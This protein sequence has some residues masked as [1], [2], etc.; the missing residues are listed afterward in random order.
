MAGAL[1]RSHHAVRFRSR[2]RLLLPQ[3]FRR[4][5]RVVQLLQGV[6]RRPARTVAHGLPDRPDA[7]RRGHNERCRRAGAHAIVFSVAAAL[8]DRASQ[9]LRDA[10]ARRRDFPQGPRAARRRRRPRQQSDRR[11]GLKRRHP[12]RRQPVRQACAQYFATARRSELLDLYEPQRRTVAVEFVQEQSIANK[13]RLEARDP[14]VRQR[15]LDELR[16]IAAD[17]ARARQFLLRTSMIASQ[18]RAEALALAKG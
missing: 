15:N 18:R 12:G 1:Y 9:S 11:H 7:E 8:R 4:P 6:G 2:T 5:R 14:A 10:P 17:P 16:A 13:K 3:L